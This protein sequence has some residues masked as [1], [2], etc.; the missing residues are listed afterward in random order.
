VASLGNSSKT[1]QMGPRGKVTP[2][3]MRRFIDRFVVLILL[4]RF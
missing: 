4:L 1:T 3:D 2:I